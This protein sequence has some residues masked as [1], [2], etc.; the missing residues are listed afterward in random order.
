MTAAPHSAPIDQIAADFDADL[1]ALRRDI[2]R[3]P[4]LAGDERRTATMAAERLR[5][6]GLSVSTGVGGHGVVAVLDGAG[7]GPTVA[8]RADMDAVAADELVDSEFV[9]QVPGAAHLC[10]HDL[11][12]AI[13]VGIAQVLS[14]LRHLFSGR[15]AFAFQPAE[16][17]LNG[18]RAMIEAGFLERV[19][20]QEIYALHCAPLPVGVFAVMPGVGQPGLDV[21]YID[22]SGSSAVQSGERLVA[23]INDL[24]TV[25]RPRTPE[26]LAQLIEDLQTPSGPL[27]RFVLAESQLTLG[28]GGAARVQLWLRAWP[29][30]RYPTLRE[31]VRR[32]AGSIEAAQV[33]FPQPPFPAMVCSP[34]LSR[35]AAAHLRSVAG[36]A[37]VKVLH[38][39]FPFNGEDFALFLR[40]VPGAMFYLGVA[41]SEA[42][43]NGVPH[44]PD[45]AA[46]EKAIGLGVRA[47]AGLLLSRLDVLHRRPQQP[48]DAPIHRS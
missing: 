43:L 15:V 21:G 17:T 48:T 31:E 44:A 27:T 5:A 37:A 26:E 28:D 12:T 13:G 34:E 40:Q 46:D 35:A 32:L 39:A 11:H 20:P 23:A 47:M 2:H 45:F 41:N 3:R 38:A 25:I 7:P 36:V 22:V 8:Y 42:G 19:A 6:A 10:G 9:S 29:D 16:E 24:S 14:R 1:I 30:N 33:E 4:E 18:A